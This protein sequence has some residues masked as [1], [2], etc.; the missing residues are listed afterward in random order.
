MRQQL[1]ADMGVGAKPDAVI[2]TPYE[3]DVLIV[4]AYDAASLSSSTTATYPIKDSTANNSSMPSVSMFQ[5]LDGGDE[6]VDYPL[7]YDTVYVDSGNT[8]EE[9]SWASTHSQTSD[10]SP[11]PTAAYT[12]LT[13]HR[14]LPLPYKQHSKSRSK[15]T[16]KLKADLFGEYKHSSRHIHP[17]L[18]SYLLYTS[19]IMLN[20]LPPHM[21]T[22]VYMRMAYSHKNQPTTSKTAARV[23]SI[24]ASRQSLLNMHRMKKPLHKHV[25]RTGPLLSASADST[26]TTTKQPSSTDAETGPVISAPPQSFL[27]HAD[28]LYSSLKEYKGIVLVNVYGDSMWVGHVYDTISALTQ[29][30]GC[31]APVMFKLYSQEHLSHELIETTSAI[32]STTTTPADTSAATHTIYDNCTSN[33]NIH[34]DNNFD[35]VYKYQQVQPDSPSD[36]YNY[37]MLL[38]QLVP[39]KPSLQ[40]LKKDSEYYYTRYLSETFDRV[41]CVD[42]SAVGVSDD[43]NNMIPF[44]AV[45][46]KV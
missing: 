46:C 25:K 40:G 36:M 6:E 12:H 23:R 28:L 14:S 15:I 5:S 29:R 31:P 10:P 35:V 13:R 20:K 26:T 34:S 24:L 32:C 43:N 3:Y 21:H 22:P 2:D 38:S 19:R 11:P 17:S 7:E 42:N 4:D 27:V 16:H 37:I 33:Y 30:G 18:S 39:N 9:L 41:K 45:T 44:I 1:A 8:S